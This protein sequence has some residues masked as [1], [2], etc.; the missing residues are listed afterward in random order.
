LNPPLDQAR[1]TGHQSGMYQT[2]DPTGG[3]EYGRKNLPRLR[4]ELARLKLDGF[5]IPHEDEYQNEYVPEAL[6]RLKWA[7][8]FTGSA[9]AAI[10]LTETAAVFV[11]GRYTLQVQAQVD[12]KLF[13][14]HVYPEPGL[15][16]F[17]QDHAPHNARIG[18]DPRLHSPDAL[19]KLKDAAKARAITLVAV[20][21]NPVD[22][23]WVGRPPTPMAKIFPHPEAFS[24]EAGAAKRKRI[25]EAIAASGASACVLTSPA[26]LAWL[27]NIRGGDVKA[28]PLP[29]GSAILFED[30]AAEVFFAPEKV[31]VELK[32]FLGNEVAVHREGDFV[33]RL[34][35]L[36]GRAVSLD[37]AL[38]SAWHFETLEAAGASIVR[39]QDPV[40]LPR[41]CKNSVEVEGARQAH[42]IDGVALAKFLHWLAGEEVQAGGL[43]EITAVKTLEAFRREAHSLADISFESISGAGPNGAI[44]HYRVSTKTNRKLKRG[45]LFLIDSGGQYREGTTDVTRT[46]AIGRPSPEMRDRFTRVLK[47]HI[48]LSRVRFPVGTTGSALDVLARQAL[49]DG[50]FDYDHGTGHGVGSFLGVHEGPHRISKTPSTVALQPGMI[51]SN[52]PGFYKTGA[53]GIRI[54]N[55]QVVT[56]PAP[57]PGGERAM[58]GF[59]TLT[60][61]PIDRALIDK[62][63][64][65]LAER[66]WL[67]AYHAR[68]LAVIGPKLEGPAQTWLAGAC[69]PV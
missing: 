18:Y 9:G 4:K 58:L 15:A 34:Q 37:P 59:E 28:T 51:V 11:D 49:W 22:R 65:S 38:A 24:G 63:L 36:K 56:E 54:E 67:N 40:T 6:D 14:V 31:D 3:P 41:A 60:L 2:F 47:G 23:A 62:R 45:S 25:G 8:G 57:L 61:A 12:G 55:L 16:G 48:A 69:A 64:L 21:D 26:S 46:I 68:V 53:Y 52:E 29:L 20:T 13:G 50:G 43:D 1:P 30:G 7:T 10:V 19:A 35:A 27:F 33:D 32:R 39:A 42:A 66:E 44:V 17:L 5:I